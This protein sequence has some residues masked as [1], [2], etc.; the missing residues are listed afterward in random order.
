[1]AV[2]EVA[3]TRAPCFAERIW[4]LI[5]VHR[6]LRR[7]IEAEDRTGDGRSGPTVGAAMA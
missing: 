7:L 4:P 2:E 1:M 5:D 3:A 6:R